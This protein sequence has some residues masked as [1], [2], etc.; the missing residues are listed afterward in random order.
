M[1]NWIWVLTMA[2]KG[3]GEFLLPELWST[4]FLLLKVD[5]WVQVLKIQISAPK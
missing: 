2:N 5:L 1:Q 4:V 3:F